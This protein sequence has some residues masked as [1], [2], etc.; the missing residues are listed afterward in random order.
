MWGCPPPPALIRPRPHFSK[1]NLDNLRYSVLNRHLWIFLAPFWKFFCTQNRCFRKVLAA[2]I[3]TSTWGQKRKNR[4]FTQGKRYFLQH[5]HSC[6]EVATNEKHKKTGKPS[7]RNQVVFFHIVFSL[8]LEPIWMDF[9]L[10]VGSQKTDR[11]CLFCKLQPRGVQEAPKRL[12]ERHKGV[13]RAP[14]SLPRGPQEC[15]RATKTCS[16]HAQSASR[17]SLFSGFPCFS[18]FFYVFLRFPVFFCVFLCFFTA[19]PR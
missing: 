1:K 18:M 10:Q 14:N 16:G 4:D 6:F 9:G 12:Q 2:W 11:N 13:S 3:W 5:W 19:Y 8:I 7:L 17:G 15:P